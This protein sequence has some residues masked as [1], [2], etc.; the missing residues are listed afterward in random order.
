MSNNISF[1]CVGFIWKE[2]DPESQLDRFFKEDLWESGSDKKYL[3]IIKAVK[4]GSLLAA[5]TTF[6]KVVNNNKIS[7]SKIHS[8]GVVT[9]N[10]EDGIKLEVKWQKK[11]QP[12]EIEQNGV[13][14][15]T[16]SKVNNSQIIRQ[17][18]GN[19][20]FWIKDG[21]IPFYTTLT[22]RIDNK[23]Y[24]CFKL[25]KDEW[26]DFTYKT[27]YT[28]Y[29]HEDENTSV[30]I[31]KSKF[32]D[33]NTD[34]GNLPDFFLRL[35]DFYCSLGQDNAYYSNLKN[36]LDKK[37][38]DYYLDA[39]ND[40]SVNK[41]LSIEFDH[42]VAF[43][44]SLIRSSEAQ[45]A[46]REGKN[47]YNGVNKKNT[48]DFEFSTMIGNALEPHK[49]HFK[50]SEDDVLPFRVKV[51]I[52]KN[53]TGKTQYLSRLASTLSGL[54]DEG[55]FDSELMPPFSRV[56]TISY[57]LFDR[58]P[59][60]E[61]T[62]G[63]SYYYCGFRGGKGFLTPNQMNSRFMKAVKVLQESRR[64]SYFG[65]YLTEILDGN[66][67]DEILDEDFLEI[68]A[69][70][71]KLFYKDDYSKYSSGQLIMILVLAELIAYVTEDSL[72]LIDE[73]ETHLH[74]NSI[75]LFIGVINKILKKYESY[76]IIAT[77]SSQV[78]QEVPA[79]D[80]VVLER[81]ENVAGTRSVGLETF[82]ENLNTITQRIFN[83]INNDEYY[84]IFLKRLSKSMNYESILTEFENKSQPLSLNAKMYLQSLYEESN[85]T[86]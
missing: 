75:S 16:I 28:V 42:L 18:F 7:V 32:L 12:F 73:P 49:I 66:I 3:S 14:R 10:F 59:R 22:G 57:S 60:P 43:R 71:F 55:Y 85:T 51:L 72:I 47:V 27:Q 36:K 37:T 80:I 84:R 17:I 23:F 76:A 64:I 69:S 83:T 13:N 46:Y 31:G 34:S 63:F 8:V 30:K 52:G 24:P 45:K 2:S 50:F 25:T 11:F 35:D 5:R 54:K 44:Q 40:L 82:G 20:D 62:K 15:S 21:N 86:N 81:F 48:F 4:V 58:F 33:R 53:G 67:V 38:A 77:H 74:P 26:D 65:K 41:G 79:K 56:I 70:S 78:V 19:F 68:R 29:Y 1:Y 39:V 9:K 6:T 61:K